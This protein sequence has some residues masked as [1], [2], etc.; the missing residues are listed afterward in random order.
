MHLEDFCYW[1]WPPYYHLAIFLALSRWNQMIWSCIS[2]QHAEIETDRS[3]I[4][5]SRN[6]KQIGVQSKC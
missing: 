6:K 2:H 3:V 5:M 4:R 1:V